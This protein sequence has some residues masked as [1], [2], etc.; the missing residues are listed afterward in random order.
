M[1]SGLEKSGK[2]L[3]ISWK[4]MEIFLIWF[5]YDEDFW[6]DEAKPLYIYQGRYKNRLENKKFFVF[7]IPISYELGNSAKNPKIYMLSRNSLFAKK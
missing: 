2:Q 6:K 3:T 1:W 5:L 7:E 4:K